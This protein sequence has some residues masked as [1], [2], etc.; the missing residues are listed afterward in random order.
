LAPR[1]HSVH[2]KDIGTPIPCKLHF[3]MFTSRII[4]VS[5]ALISLSSS[6][7]LRSCNDNG[8]LVNGVCE[9]FESFSGPNCEHFLAHACVNGHCEAP[10][11]YC[12]YGNV[13][14]SSKL[15]GGRPGWCLPLM[16]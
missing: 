1:Y 16:K 13:Y 5:F 9:C 15:C 8:R 4:L 14:C 3:N 11:T 2:S 10:G 6:Y 7:V 12:S